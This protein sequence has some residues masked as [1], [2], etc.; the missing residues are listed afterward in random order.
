MKMQSG[1]KTRS[2]CIILPGYDEKRRALGP[3]N[4]S[5][6]PALPSRLRWTRAVT[7][8]SILPFNRFK[9][10]VVLYHFS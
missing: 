8:K 10:D 9:L 3:V 7:E 6:L 2:G 1:S 4:R 5:R